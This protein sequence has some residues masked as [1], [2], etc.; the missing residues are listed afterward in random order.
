MLIYRMLIERRRRLKEGRRR[1]VAVQL[2]MLPL[3]SIN[4]RLFGQQYPFDIVSELH[5]H[6]QTVFVYSAFRA[7]PR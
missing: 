2:S 7:M 1:N 6:D 5:S 3:Q 4:Y